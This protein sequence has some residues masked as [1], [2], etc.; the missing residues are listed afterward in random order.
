MKKQFENILVTG[1]AGFIGSAFIRFG[2]S[3]F[4]WIKKIVN[5]DSLTYASNLNSLKKVEGDSRYI[6]VRGNVLNGVLVEKLC[7]EHRIQAIVHFAAESHV[8]RSI[9]TPKVF[10]ETNVGGTI[11]L[12]EV[13]RRFPTIHFHQISTDE[14]YGSI[15]EG[16][17]TEEAPYNPQSPYAASKAAA[18]HFVRAYAHTYGLSVTLS[19]STNNYGPFQHNEKFIPQMIY[20]C[21]EKKVLPIYGEGV[22]VRNW[23]Y[24]D[25]H[26]EAIWMVL[27][28]GKKGESYHISG[29]FE[30]RNIDLAR[31]LVEKFAHLTR[32]DPSSFLESITFVKDRPGHDFRYGISSKKVKREFGWTPKCIF[33]L[34]IEKTIKWY[35]HENSVCY[36]S[37]A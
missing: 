35:L 19:H 5:L 10:Y 23:I 6:F 29:E 16:F 28:S 7:L 32:E 9:G 30:T 4:P 11:A 22:N 8:D 14:V 37:K 13:V 31:F 17:V 3:C 2:L 21:M 18:D 15:K 25:D 1:G 12:L 26:V 34:G 24:V 27:Q 20:S 36:S 33:H